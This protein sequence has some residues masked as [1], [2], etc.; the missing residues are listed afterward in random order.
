MLS[1]EECPITTDIQWLVLSLAA[2]LA[3]SF[4]NY[5]NTLVNFSFARMRKKYIEDNDEQD[6]ELIRKV[7]PFYQR[8]SQILGGTQVAFVIY[9]GIFAISLLG[10]A[11]SGRHL[12]LALMG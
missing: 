4:F 3:A 11:E 7:A 5:K 8:T 10:M 12:L 1:K 2:A 6:P 9:C